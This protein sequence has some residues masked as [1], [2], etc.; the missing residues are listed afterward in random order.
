MRPLIKCCGPIFQN[1]RLQNEKTRKNG[2]IALQKEEVLMKKVTVLVVVVIGCLLFGGV[3]M[4]QEKR[5]VDIVLDGCSKEIETYCKN[6]TP[7]EG[8]GLAC[9]YAYSDKL[10]NRCEYSLYDAAAQLERLLNGLSY[11]AS[12]C[13]DELK[14]YCSDIQPGQGRILECLAKKKDMAGSRCKSAMED[15][16]LK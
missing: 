7:G 4:A 14:K 15:V 11:L 5:P 6:V 8:R 13:R 2:K 12:E 16:R 9:L 1:G 10:S 3:V